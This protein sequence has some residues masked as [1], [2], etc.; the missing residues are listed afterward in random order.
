MPL[1][2]K[3]IQNLKKYQKFILS[4]FINQNNYMEGSGSATIN[5]VALPK[6]PEEEETSPNK[7]QGG[8][9]CLHY[10]NSSVLKCT[11]YVVF[12]VSYMKG[13]GQR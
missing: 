13:P 10:S 5:N 7:N 4:F 11:M 12:Q 1:N 8:K 3:S 6:H 2:K 9:I